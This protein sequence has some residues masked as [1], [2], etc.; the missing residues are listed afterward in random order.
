MWNDTNKGNSGGSESHDKAPQSSNSNGASQSMSSE[1][2]PPPPYSVQDPMLP[3]NPPEAN[4]NA[5]VT[6]PTII[7][8]NPQP[9]AYANAPIQYHVKQNQSKKRSKYPGKVN[10]SYGQAYG[11]LQDQINS[12]RYKG[13]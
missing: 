1:A 10:A 11:N 2:P 9:M 12:G 3:H 6:G 13:P 4:P 5:N 8:G 7:P